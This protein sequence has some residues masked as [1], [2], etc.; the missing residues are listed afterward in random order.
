MDKLLPLGRRLLPVVRED[1]PASSSPA[2]LGTGQDWESLQRKRVLVVLGE[3]GSGKTSELTLRCRQLKDAELPAFRLAIEGLAELGVEDGIADFAER[4]RFREWHAT[5]TAAGWFFLDALDESKLRGHTLERSVRR[6]ARDL[7]AGISRAHVVLSSRPSDWRRSDETS[8]LGLLADI[9]RVARPRGHE[10]MIF[11]LAPLERDQVLVLASHREG[12]DVGALRAAIDDADAWSLLTRPMDVL[13]LLQHWKEHGRLGSRR[14]LVRSSVDKRLGDAG[15]RSAGIARDRA[16][17]GARRLALAG[18]LTGALEIALPGEPAAG[19]LAPDGV[20]RDWPPPEVEDLL[21]LGLFDEATYGRVRFHE[22]SVQDFLAAEALSALVAAG[23]SKADLLA[24]LF[25]LAGGRVVVPNRL[26]GT[27]AWLAGTNADVR[28]TALERAPE[29]LLDE[30]DPGTFPPEERIAILR[31]YVARFADRAHVPFGFDAQGLGRFGSPAMAATIVHM[32]EAVDTPDHGRLLLLQI[33]ASARLGAVGDAAL[34]IA[35][36]PH[37]S[38]RLRVAAIDAAAAVGAAFRPGLAAL[39]GTSAARDSDVAAALAATL[40]PATIGGAE[41]VRLLVNA[42]REPLQLTRLEVEAAAL[43]DRCDVAQLGELLGALVRAI[44]GAQR[45]QEGGRPPLDPSRAWLGEALASAVDHALALTDTPPDAVAA[46]VDLLLTLDREG[47]GHGEDRGRWAVEG[48]DRLRRALFWER[49][50]RLRAQRRSAPD[51]SDMLPRMRPEDATWLSIDSVSKERVGDRVLAFACLIAARGGDASSPELDRLAERGDSEHG[52]DALSKHL[53]Q[54]RDFVSVPFPGE[55]A[56]A[57]R[58]TVRLSREAALRLENRDALQLRIAGIRDGSDFHA[59]HHLY[60]PSE[61]AGS[62][63]R[64]QEIEEAYGSEIASAAVDGF[65]AFWRREDAPRKED[66]QASSTPVSTMLALA[67]LEEE[68]AAGEAIHRLNDPLFRR[69]VTYG[70]WQLNRF[71]AWFEECADTRPDVV[72]EVLAGALTMD[73]ARE[74]G[75]GSMDRVLHKVAYAAAGVRRACAPTMV[76]L[77]RAGDPAQLPDLIHALQIVRGDRVVG[78]PCIADL[79]A[80]RLAAAAGDPQRFAIWWVE[81]LGVDPDEALRVL[82]DAAVADGPPGRLVV[83][84]LAQLDAAVLGVRPM[85]LHRHELAAGALTDRVMLTELFRLAATHVRVEDDLRHRGAYSPVARDAAQGAR[86]ALLS[87]LASLPGP[88]TILA[89]D[90]LAVDPALAPWRDRLRGLSDQRAVDDAGARVLSPDDV[91]TLL[92]RHVLPPQ[93]TDELLD[94]VLARL[95]DI[96]HDIL[97]GQFSNRELFDR[98]ADNPL[99]VSVQKHVAGCLDGARRDR[100]AVHREAELAD[101]TM[102][103]IRAENPRCGSPI[104]I[105]MKVAERWSGPD[106]VT[107]LR[108]Q[109]VEQYL[110]ARNSTHGVFLLCSGGPRKKAWQ[111]QGAKRGGLP[112]LAAHLHAHAVQ[113]IAERPGIEAIAIVVIDFHAGAEMLPALVARRVASRMPLGG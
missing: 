41:V 82:R 58:A 29:H 18:V 102:P 64:R 69:A 19:A 100:Y 5:G 71:P 34:R 86:G 39:A 68:Q 11:E 112:A 17:D 73:Y 33:A 61:S 75:D 74:A 27:T 31:G 92:S 32:L 111:P 49:A 54:R 8:A 70:C 87:R 10:P 91:V 95:D 101:G 109:L 44:G 42:E 28:R 4:V 97:H 98:L 78:Q 65:R 23:M 103:D 105:E 89:L 106:L 46:A 14:E 108:V 26:V 50:R 59:L 45:T 16:R 35:I 81:L 22:R 90:S 47:G 48:N 93:T 67:G 51:L 30:G 88:E 62:P 20:L 84:V 94:I 55:R 25:K 80:A 107:A 2:Y 53:R 12:L 57:L 52:S 76:D 56:L 60:T 3:A 85:Y 110:A 63:T 24:T 13:W 21:R 96:Q 43:Y 38:V 40:F 15:E 104:S 79:A 113:L 7:G 1:D 83:E 36:Q 37:A 72:S 6:F 99:E 77:L 9:T 66:A